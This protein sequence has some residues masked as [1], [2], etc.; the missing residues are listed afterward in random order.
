MTYPHPNPHPKTLQPKE[1][2]PQEFGDVHNTGLV[3]EES[4]AK[5]AARRNLADALANEYY[6]SRHA[7]LATSRSGE[8]R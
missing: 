7:S 6:R 4:A 3:G 2:S 8:S 1:L 5:A